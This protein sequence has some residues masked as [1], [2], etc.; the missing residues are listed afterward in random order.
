MRTAPLAKQNRPGARKLRNQVQRDAGKRSG[1]L[2]SLGQRVR[3]EQ[4]GQ[5][6]VHRRSDLRSARSVLSNTPEGLVVRLAQESAPGGSHRRARRGGR[7]TGR[8]L[9]GEGFRRGATGSRGRSGAVLAEPVSGLLAWLK[10]CGCRRHRDDT[11]PRSEGYPRVQAQRLNTLY[12]CASSYLQ[13]NHTTAP[14]Q[15]MPRLS[16]SYKAGASAL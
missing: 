10:G 11:E 3:A 13:G 4:T 16:C 1:S 15:H 5:Q 7:L 8:E 12:T 14:T 6:A 9:T 2:V